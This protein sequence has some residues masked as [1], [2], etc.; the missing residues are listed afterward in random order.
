MM[1]SKL[2][3]ALD[4]VSKTKRRSEKIEIVSDILSAAEEHEIKPITN[5]LAGT[6]FGESEEKTLNVSWKGL[7]QVL[8]G[9]YEFTDS[10]ISEQYEGDVGAAIESLL[11]GGSFAGQSVLFSDDLTVERVMQTFEKLSQLSGKGSA[12]ER[13]ALLSGLL[14][15]ADP[16][17]TRYLVALILNDMRTGL[18]EGLLAMGIGQAFQI[19]EHL[20]RRAWSFTGNLGMTALIAKISGKQGLL[21]VSIDYFRPVKPMLATPANSIDELLGDEPQGF[22]FE[23]KLDGARVQIHKKGDDVKIYSRRLNDVTE[24]LPDVVRI[25]LS[26]FKSNLILD[27]EVIAVDTTGKPFP[28]QVVMKRFGRTQEVEIAHKE[29]RLA[30][31]VFDILRKE[32]EILSD[33]TNAVRW[34]VLES[35][36]PEDLR[37][38]RIVSKNPKE[39][40]A[41]FQESKELGHEGLVAKRISSRYVP[42][43][44]GKLWYKLKHSLETLD[45]V[46]IGAERGHGRRAK[47]LSDFHLAVV[48]EETGEYAMVGKTF[49]G[50]TDAEFQEITSRLEK[51]ALSREGGVVQVKPQ[52]VVEVL[53]AEIQDSP[54]YESGMALRFARIKKIRYDKSVKDATTLLE[55]RQM[56]ERQFRYKAR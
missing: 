49:K 1:F 4:A 27:G 7:I 15:E 53:A 14:S 2:A 56:Y 20:V 44:R 36:V 13:R 30:L 50:L 17:E 38:S 29:T 18:S 47:W 34:S 24:G 43:T 54:T 51:I 46:I 32:D 11:V 40:E 22:A 10:Q 6:I 12:K 39:I 3:K 55:L 48:D 25:I 5:F 23:L 26:K 37:V 16:L 19:E 33:L 41:F 8:K 42:G 21:D 9:I 52:I 31:Y 28:F 35:V 45:L